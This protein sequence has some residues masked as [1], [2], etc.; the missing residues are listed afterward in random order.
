M[1]TRHEE[2]PFKAVRTP[3]L[4]KDDYVWIDER[5]RLFWR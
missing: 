3:D 2:I 4:A 5:L 1:A